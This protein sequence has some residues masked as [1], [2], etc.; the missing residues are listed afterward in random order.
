MVV[1]PPTAIEAASLRKTFGR[2]TAVDDVSL[3]VPT[4]SVCGL[5]GTNGAGKTTTVRMLSTLLRP[6]GGS[7]RIFGRD[8]ATQG[9]AVRSL[10]ALTG[11]YASLD[12]DLSAEENLRLFAELRG[13]SKVRARSRA[14]DLIGQFGLSHAARR[15]V[16]GYSG[17]MRRRL[18]LACSLI[19][20]PPLLFLDEP[21]TGLDPATRAQVWQAV[22][23]LV[24]GGTT[25]LLTTQYLDEADK[26]SDSIVVMDSGRV[27]AEGTADTLKERIGTKSLH[28]IITDAA[29]LPR[30]AGVLQ[31]SLG[32]EVAQVAGEARLSASITDPGLAARAVADLEA[33]S[34][35]IVEFSVQRPTLDDV[36]FALTGDPATHDAAGNEISW[37]DAS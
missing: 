1:L 30:A 21:T 29:Q 25:V 7:A 10:I 37:Q 11:Q 23:E 20:A 35:G 4:G 8:V 22:R 9:T 28:V 6:D 18:D 32:T 33:A 27:V 34:V 12:E 16:S 36:F 14:D 13:F 31:Q 2:V 24:S 15:A 26:L 17:G 3:S 5:L 19:T